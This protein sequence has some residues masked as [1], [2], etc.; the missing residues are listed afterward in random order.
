MLDGITGLVTKA[1]SLEELIAALRSLL[2]DPA[3]IAEMGGN[4]RSFTEQGALSM[5]EACATI[6]EPKVANY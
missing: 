2:L 3:R 4:A 1:D 6:L 5:T